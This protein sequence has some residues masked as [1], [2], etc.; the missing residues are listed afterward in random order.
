M[1]QDVITQQ[2]ASV[3]QL[4]ALVIHKEPIFR[5]VFTEHLFDWRRRQAGGGFE[6][7]PSKCLFEA[8]LIQQKFK[9]QGGFI[10]FAGINNAFFGGGGVEVNLGVFLFDLS[11]DFTSVTV[12]DFAVGAGTNAQVI[13]ELPVVEVV[14]THVAW[15]RVGRHF[16]L[17]KTMFDQ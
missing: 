14:L 12:G 2:K 7:I 10:K 5:Y 13:T 17:F 15:P 11:L 4:Q 3:S 9:W 16:V 8:Q 1:L 6:L